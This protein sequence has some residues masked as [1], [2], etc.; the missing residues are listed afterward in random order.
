MGQRPARD[1]A[2]P[3]GDDVHHALA[4]RERDEQRRE[5]ERAPQQRVVE[6][7]HLDHHPAQP[8]GVR[9]RDLERG[10]RAERRA[11][12]GRLLELQVVQ[13]RDYLLC[14]ELHRVAPHVARAVRLAVPE[15]IDREHVVAARREI[16]GERAVH[17]PGEQ[18]SV[19]QDYRPCARGRAARGAPAIAALREDRRTAAELLVD[20]PLSLEL[21]R[22]HVR[23]LPTPAR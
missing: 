9:R 2:R 22:G 3:P 5:R 10:V 17:L 20:D 21:E 4:E 13:Q 6:H 12:Y 14:E 1:R 18:Q 16:F 15:E 7:R 19:D 23:T 8:L 11:H